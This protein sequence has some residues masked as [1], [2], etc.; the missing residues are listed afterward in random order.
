MFAFLSAG[1]IQV[2]GKIWP[3]YEYIMAPDANE[4]YNKFDIG[5]VYFGAKGDLSK[6]VGARVTYE[7]K[8]LSD[9]Y[10]NIYLKY[11]Y[12]E[13]K[14]FFPGF[15]VLFG[16]AGLPWVPFEEKLWGFRYVQKVMP[17]LGGKLTSTDLGLSVIYK[18]PGGYG[19][20]HGAGVN[21]TGYH[22]V[23]NNK[24][25]DV[26]G[27]L[28][29]TPMPKSD[30]LKGLK[31]SGFASYGFIVDEDVTRQRLITNLFYKYDFLSLGGTILWTRDDE[32][33][34]LGAVVDTTKSTGYS[35][36]CTINFGKLMQKKYN[37][38]IFARYDNF[39][40]NTDVN[41]NGWTKIIVGFFHEI[42]KGTRIGVDL[43][44]KSY[45]ASGVDTEREIYLHTEVKFK[46]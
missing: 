45:E 31:I 43:Q 20:F 34:S 14:E 30:F 19:E 23:E 10:I 4:N 15:K 41:D 8:R 21:G 39:D 26:H 18:F 38:G 35:A 3:Y 40:P 5:R 17:D 27:R 9:G 1:K 32:P 7:I 25:K 36:Y 42:I 16:Q 29:I 24:Y 11:C 6:N 33:D 22:A 12:L 44:Q 13:L 28:T 2:Q 46:I 37:Y